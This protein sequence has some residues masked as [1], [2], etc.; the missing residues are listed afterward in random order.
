MLNDFCRYIGALGAAKLMPIAATAPASFL[1]EIKA[2]KDSRNALVFV[3]L[4]IEPEVVVYLNHCQECLCMSHTVDKLL[5]RFA[6]VAT[7]L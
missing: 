2:D 4:W 6:S 5:K 3:H 7:R 1:F